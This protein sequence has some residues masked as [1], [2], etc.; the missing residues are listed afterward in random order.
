MK[1]L[2]LDQFV[3]L[4]LWIALYIMLLCHILLVVLQIVLQTTLFSFIKWLFYKLLLI[5]DEVHD[6]SEHNFNTL[7]MYKFP[8]FLKLELCNFFLF[9]LSIISWH[10]G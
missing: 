9:V 8:S 1:A 7:W 10:A 2:T 5:S 3:W 4:G 6:L